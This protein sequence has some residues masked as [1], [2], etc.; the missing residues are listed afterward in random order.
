MVSSIE[1]VRRVVRVDRVFDAAGCKRVVRVDRV[2]DAAGCKAIFG[3][4]TRVR[5]GKTT[6]HESGQRSS[7]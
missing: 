6:F 4:P 7:L 1:K 2:F 3:T 5:G